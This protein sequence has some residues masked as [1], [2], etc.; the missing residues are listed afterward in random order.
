MPSLK[1]TIEYVKDSR[2]WKILSRNSVIIPITVAAV[3]AVYVAVAQDFFAKRTRLPNTNNR[4]MLSNNVTDSKNFVVNFFRDFVT[5][6]FNLW[7]NIKGSSVNLYSN[8]T[9][10]FSSLYRNF[11]DNVNV[12]TN[13]LIAGNRFSQGFAAFVNVLTP[14]AILSAFYNGTKPFLKAIL[15][16]SWF[17][18]QGDA[19][20][21]GAAAAAAAAGVVSAVKEE[22]QEKTSSIWEKF[23]NYFSPKK[24]EENKPR[25]SEEE[26]EQQLQGGASEG[27]DKEKTPP[28]SPKGA[29]VDEA[30]GQAHAG[31]SA[32]Q[33]DNKRLT[34]ALGEKDKKVAAAK[35][36]ATQ[37][38]K[39]LATQSALLQGQIDGLSAHLDA[40]NTSKA[41]AETARLVAEQALT[42]HQTEAAK[43]AR[44]AE[45]Q[46]KVAVTAAAG[47]GAAA[48]QTRK[49]LG[50]H[51]GAVS[52]NDGDIPPASPK[53]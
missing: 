20:R 27:S 49:V 12:A 15:P 8:V 28:V 50:Q 31:V 47:A 40:A 24:A 19:P 33:Q 43:L 18:G 53:R 11:S 13:P 41:A 6:A 16:A 30:A 10:Y 42:Q 2:P 22:A 7:S 1:S 48:H 39:D 52:S 9:G 23:K 35:D 37:A 4:N 51:T 17:D 21:R 38:K 14:L 5:F 26:K 46:A 29:G 36:E 45:E 3:Y 34:A 25:R 32:L 44:R